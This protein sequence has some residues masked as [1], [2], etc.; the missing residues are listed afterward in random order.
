MTLRANDPDTYLN[1]GIC[2]LKKGLAA[3]GR[4]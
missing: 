3:R 2:L 4:R 1:R